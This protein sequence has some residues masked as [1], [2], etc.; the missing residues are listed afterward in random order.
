[1][2]KIYIK[3]VIREKETKS[4]RKIRYIGSY[5]IFPLLLKEIS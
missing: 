2:R 1:M 3:N 4:N 5:N